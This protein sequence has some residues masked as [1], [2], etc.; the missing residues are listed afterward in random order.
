MLNALVFVVFLYILLRTQ[1]GT[2]VGESIREL[3]GLSKKLAA[4]RGPPRVVEVQ[5]ATR[6]DVPSQANE[7]LGAQ[8]AANEISLSSANASWQEQQVV[9]AR[10]EREWR[11]G[12]G[13]AAKALTTLLGGGKLMRMSCSRH[14]PSP[15]GPSKNTS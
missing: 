9:N 5:G 4:V 6:S 13:R 8:K 15:C 7:A 10:L 3:Q 1:D 12:H 14:Q 11:E 2:L